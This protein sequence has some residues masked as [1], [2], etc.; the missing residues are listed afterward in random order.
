MFYGK[1]TIL[2]LTWICATLML[3]GSA[4]AVTEADII[5][6]KAKAARGETFTQAERLLA[7]QARREFGSLFAPP[8]VPDAPR[9]PNNTLDEYIIAD[10]PY[11]W[12]DITEVGNDAELVN[13]D[14]SVGPFDLGFSFTYYEQTFT[15]VYMTS[16]GWCTFDDQGGWASYSNM[17]IPDGFE[18]NNAAYIFWDD[19]YPPNGGQYYY[20]ADEANQRFVMTWVDVPH[21][22]TTDE[23][24]TFQIILTPDGNIRYNYQHVHEGGIY[25]NLSCTVGIE[26]STSDE[27][28]QRCNEGTGD[29][30]LSETSVLVG[31]PDGVPGPVTNLAAVVND[32]DVTLTWIEPTQDTNGNPVT[33]TNLEVWIGRP[34]QG[35]LVTTVAP[36]AQSVTLTNQND[37]SRT[38]YVRAFATPYYGGSDFVNIIVGTPSYANNFDVDEGLWTTDNGWYWGTPTN[39]IGPLPYS[40]PNTWGTDFVAGYPDEADYSLYLDVGLTVATEDAE[41]EF[42]A[43]F[44]NE[45]FWDGCNMKVSLDGG[46]TWE[47]VEPEG[48]YSVTMLNEGTANPLAGEPA[49]SGQSDG[50]TYI[51]IPLGQYV[52]Q[53][54]LFRLHFGSD[55][56][57]SGY[58]G[59]YFDDMIIWGLAEPV[60]STVSGSITMDGGAGSVTAVTVRADGLGSP[61]THPLGDNS[62]T[63]DNVLVG[64]RRIRATLDGYHTAQTQIA[65]P[66][67]GINGVNLTL[68]RLDPPPATNLVGTVNS[69]S[70]LCNLTWTAAADPLVDEYHIFR[71]LAGDQDYVQVGTSPTTSFS[72][73]LTADGIYQ[74]T[75]T[76]VDLNVSTPVESEPSNVVT[77]LFGELPV[78]SLGANGNFDDR[79]RLSWLTPG[80]LEGTELGYDDGSAEQFYVVAFPAGPEDYF[81]VRM[82]PPDDA[83]YPILLFGINIFVEDQLNVPW[84][85]LCPPS[86]AFEG[87]DITAPL[88]VWTDLHAD[89]TPGW[90]YA[91]TAGDAF[92][93]EAGDFY[94]VYQFP[95]GQDDQPAVGSDL[96][97]VD[98]RSYWTQTPNDVW[99]LWTAHDWMMR[100][101]L[102]GPP[103]EDPGANHAPQDYYLLS[104]GSAT[105]YSI[106]R[107]ASLPVVG[108]RPNPTEITSRDVDEIRAAGPRRPIVTNTNPLDRWFAPY[109]QAPEVQL[110]SRE[111]RDALDDIVNY[112]VY[113]GGTMIA[114]PVETNYTDLNRIENTSY[115]Y[116]VTAMYDNGIESPPSPTRTA[117]CNM[118]P[119]APTG[120]VGT[121]QGNTQMVLAWVGPTTNADGSPLVDLAQYRVYRNGEQIAT[122]A[123]GTTT[124]I[125]TPP[126]ND[127]Y[128]TWTVTALDEVPNISAPSDPYVGAV[129]LPYESVDYEWVDIE[130]NG[131]EIVFDWWGAT[132]GPFDLGFAF[133]YFEQEHTQ[134]WISPGGWAALVEL[135]GGF[136]SNQNL[137]APFEPH[138]AIYPFWDELA[139]GLD[140]GRVLYLQDDGRFIISWLDVP[141]LWDFTFRYTFQLILDDNGGA[142]FNYHTI[143]SDAWPGNQDCTVGVE[144]QT[145]T[146][147]VNVYSYGV[148]DIA[149]VSETAIAF[150]GGPSGEIT[151]LIREFGSNVPLGNVEVRVDQ[152]PDVFVTSDAGGLYVLEVEPGTYTLRVHRQGY[153]DQVVNNVVVVED[154]SATNNFSMRQ[155]NA[156]FSV[157]S[158]NILS[159]TGQN[160]TASFEITNP[161][162]TCDLEYTITATQPWLSVTPA[163]GDVQSNQ[164][165]T[166]NVTGA[167]ANFAPGDY[168]ATINVA[169]NDNNSPLAIPVTIS[170][171]LS[172]DDAAEIPTAFAL[173][174]NYPNPFNA[175]TVLR[176]DVP[177]ESRVEVVLYNVQGQE[178][179]R[180]VDQLMAAGRHEVNFDAAG[181]PTGMYLAKMSAADFSAVQKIVLLK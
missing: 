121:P 155:P 22:G 108:N 23:L 40:E 87:P 162:A 137:P 68:T 140:G 24:Y 14:Q 165:Q 18:P 128:Y 154:G 38:M 156:T 3:V 70:G 58:P 180:P 105:G 76:A 174:Q 52:G 178:V 47:I 63:I 29:L 139:A 35:A 89:E 57:V 61:S 25:G 103:P 84:I 27:G 97:E 32:H 151:G 33:L 4:F 81:C 115:S 10:V 167:T 130:G 100:A 106:E 150:W 120:L 41:M 71:R 13:D 173:H 72:Q 45:F 9:L 62:F 31:Q 149:P 159:V 116:H 67:G 30:P 20:Y 64:N 79:I 96:N 163:T 39:P 83:S 94:I 65:V 134:V 55:E 8:R 19:L 12:V 158:L 49:W 66:E 104:T 132:A 6:L 143:P 176:F 7:D 50:W 69:V 95:Q 169:H 144:D 92:L 133:P 2:A 86:A 131:T 112:R 181:L 48:G 36:G 54:P 152:V 141:H 80:T 74:Y 85:A 98:N 142:T 145:S 37:G 77:V 75:I 51:D 110:V 43:W 175:T 60:L 136:Y 147:G 26:N 124:Y 82:T 113:R 59:F 102:G 123:P 93:T 15:Q 5:R 166:I 107:V 171:A 164:T 161:G 125:D 91:E 114:Q 135:F 129:V 101:W 90:I 11:E 122:T 21:I 73:T 111:G 160:A 148:G 170:V 99:N 138:G 117:M 177:T 16:N 119:A 1:K 46:E 126:Q 17:E 118:E 56:V 179:A 127:G 78:T 28:V 88:Y 109:V 53:A 172:H 153:C 44:D 168:T 157:T 146:S 34:G 42:Y